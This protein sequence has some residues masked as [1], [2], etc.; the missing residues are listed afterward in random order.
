MECG[1]PQ[2]SGLGPL[3]CY[4]FYQ[5]FTDRTK[6]N[7]ELTPYVDDTLLYVWATTPADLTAILNKELD[8][9]ETGDRMIPALLLSTCF[10]IQDSYSYLK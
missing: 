2:G 8:I 1:V 5:W 10:T 4:L 7:A 6:E 9:I 3:M